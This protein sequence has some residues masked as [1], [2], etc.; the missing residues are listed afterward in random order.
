MIVARPT[1]DSIPS[2]NLLQASKRNIRTQ[3][4]VC[5]TAER[6]APKDTVY[7]G[8][9]THKINGK[10]LNFC[11]IHTLQSKILC[12]SSSLSPNTACV[13][14][15]RRRLFVLRYPSRLCQISECFFCVAC[16]MDLS[17]RYVFFTTIL[18]GRLIRIECDAINFADNLG[19]R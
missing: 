12:S 9:W 5:A 19:H 14:D 2:P 16:C 1:T 18:H 3:L 6:R 11:N 8:A 4:C 17:R 15:I 10:L 13:F 7:G